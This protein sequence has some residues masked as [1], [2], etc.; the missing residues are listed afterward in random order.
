MTSTTADVG[1]TSS[2]SQNKPSRLR[3]RLAFVL[4]IMFW[5]IFVATFLLDFQER[6]VSQESVLSEYQQEI[7]IDWSETGP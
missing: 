1:L 7:G 3:E 5:L 6:K 4:N 2:V